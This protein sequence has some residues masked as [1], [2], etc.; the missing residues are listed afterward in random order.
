MSQSLALLSHN[1][2]A[3]FKRWYYISMELSESKELFLETM[4]DFYEQGIEHVSHSVM[5]DALEARVRT[6]EFPGNFLVASLHRARELRQ[7]RTRAIVYVSALE[8]K[9]AGLITQEIEPPSAGPI[10]GMQY[11]LTEPVRD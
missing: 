11:Q 9:E 6:M 5:Q 10:R 7:L 1:W 2:G 8:L 3:N 4:R